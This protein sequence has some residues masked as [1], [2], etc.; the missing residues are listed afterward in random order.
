MKL[1]I[2]SIR[3]S[4]AGTLVASSLIGLAGGCTG[5]TKKGLEARE[6]ATH[7]FNS[8]RSRI[9]YDQAMQAFKRGQMIEAQRSLQKAMHTLPDEST[10]FV[11]L[12][13]ICFETSQLEGAINAFTRASEIDDALPDPRYYLGIIAE[14]LHQPDEAA[15]RYLEAADRDPETVQ[16]I[17]A[18]VEVLIGEGR[19]GEASSILSRRAGRFTN[20]AVI[21]HLRGRIAMMHGQ[22]H[23]AADELRRASLI[24]D[25][26]MWLLADLARAQLAAGHHSA[27]LTTLLQ[28]ELQ[29]DESERDIE[30]QRLRSRCLVDARRFP[31]AHKALCAFTLRYPDDVEAW[32]DLGLVCRE[33][34]DR[35]RLRKAATRASSL[36]RSRFE[37]YF[38]LGCSFHDEGM[39]DEAVRCFTEAARLAPERS[40]TWLAL[41]MALERAGQLAEAMRA[42]GRADSMDG[43]VLMSQVATGEE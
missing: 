15:A 5:P 42:Y 34:R 32:I 21:H 7:H 35:A 41:G 10:H 33:V 39:Y 40:Q 28:I 26:D 6:R 12:G 14:R 43:R 24:D 37:G 25:G 8:V 20:N 4:L 16:Y 2:L 36:D 30:V 13:R 17:T 29:F 19:L 31:E 1:G 11:L 38:L 22:W 18:A 9:D 27:C 23:E 3:R